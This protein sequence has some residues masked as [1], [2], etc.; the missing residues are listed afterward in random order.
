MTA[1]LADSVARFAADWRHWPARARADPPRLAAY[2]PDESAARLSVLTDLVRIDIRHRWERPGLGKRIIEYRREFPEFA[3]SP[4]LVDLLCEEFVARRRGAALPLADFLAEYP[5]LAEDVRMRLEAIGADRIDARLLHIDRSLRAIAPGQRIDDFDLLTELGGAAPD[6]RVFLARQRSMQ[7]LVTVRL[8]IGGGDE[9]DPQARLDHPHIVRVFDHRMV[10]YGAGPESGRLVYLQYLPGGTL[11]EVLAR[12]RAA[13][14]TARGRDL[15]RAVDAAMEAKGEIPPADSPTRAELAALGWPETVAWVGRRLADALDYA[16][17]HGVGH[18]ALKPSSVVFTAEGEPKLADFA[19]AATPDIAADIRD[20][21]A[22]LCEMLTGTSLFDDTEA[23]FDPDAVLADCPAALRRVLLTCLESDPAHRWSSGAVLAQQLDLCL[24]ARARDLV[25]PPPD[26]PRRR[27]RHWR[28]PVLALAIVIPNAL[29]SLYN[30]V[31]GQALIT[32]R[33]SAA[34]QER[35]DLTT[36]VTNAVYFGVGTAVLV[37]FGRYL[38][39]VPHGLRLG[40]RYS[41]R[42]L[43]RARTSTI[44]F[45]HRALLVVF[46][47]WLLSGVSFPVLLLGTGED[48]PSAYAYAHF[49]VSHVI[50]GAIALVYPFFLVNFY[51]IR[52]I[53]PMFLS[54]GEV[55]ALD[56]V[57]LHRL[58]RQCGRWLLVAA[59]IPLLSVAGATLLVPADLAEIIVV[60]RLLAI[61]SLAAFL[62]GYVLFMALERDLRALERVLSGR[63][64]A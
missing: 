60:L 30:I 20:L 28:I 3:H 57:R 26:S 62:G 21:G 24:D 59:A 43:D 18:R 4:D 38:I 12:R 44:R 25:D 51:L 33:L 54:H 16:A 42:T 8:S 37:Y 17:R 32:D 45:G 2:V 11:T 36:A 5:E 1:R 64:G 34:A 41:P 50:C 14:D 35:I 19:P 9:P 46:S 7:R 15:L 63:V 55:G 52:C 27:L 31:H 6:C 23:G 22:L 58:R 48:S 56:A 13:G 47:M 61:G 53:Y 10:V 29:A 49:F 40:V 39:L